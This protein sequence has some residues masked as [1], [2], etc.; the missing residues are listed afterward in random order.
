MTT[1]RVKN[2]HYACHS[3]MGNW[4]AHLSQKIKVSNALNIVW[5][6]MRRMDV[7]RAMF[8]VA[9]GKDPRVASILF[10]FDG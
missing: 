3:P 5:K 7:I 10:G 6:R 4:A 8:D 9:V 2:E 1:E